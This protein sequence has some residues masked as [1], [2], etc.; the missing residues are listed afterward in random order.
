VPELICS[1]AELTFPPRIP[2][3]DLLVDERTEE[4]NCATITYTNQIRSVINRDDMIG[5]E[6]FPEVPVDEVNLHYVLNPPDF[7]SPTSFTKIALQLIQSP[8]STD[9]RVL[10]PFLSDNNTIEYRFEYTLDSSSCL[11][12]WFW[13]PIT[14]K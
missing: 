9:W 12:P 1:S 8:T 11:T 13:W 14:S 3:D 10:L 4:K 7:S 6:F 5:I 2:P